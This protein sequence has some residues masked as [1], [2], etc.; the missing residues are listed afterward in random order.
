MFHLIDKWLKTLKPEDMQ[1]AL[2]K[3]T[4]SRSMSRRG[5]IAGLT[6]GL[7]GVS[8]GIITPSR[9]LLVA[10]PNYYISDLYKLTIAVAYLRP[11]QEPLYDAEA[12]DFTAGDKTVLEFFQRPVGTDIPPVY[13]FAIT[14][15]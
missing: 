15:A 5:F 1:P 2:G 10:A 11:I 3:I 9:K 6:A 4:A 14:A 12:F 13:P 8:T 7:I